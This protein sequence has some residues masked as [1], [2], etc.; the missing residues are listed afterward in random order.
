MYLSPFLALID[1]QVQAAADDALLLSTPI[2]FKDGVVI[3]KLHVPAG[4]QVAVPIAV[5]NRM[6]SLWGEDAWEF[7]PERWLDGGVGIPAAIKDI[8]GHQHLL[9]F[10]SGPKM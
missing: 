9:T 2:T 4:T 8:Q 7:K 6:R 1:L 5:V 10:I 3:D